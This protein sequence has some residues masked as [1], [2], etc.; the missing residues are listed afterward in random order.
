[1]NGVR[2]YTKEYAKTH[3]TQNNGIFVSG[4]DNNSVTE[5]YGELKNILELRYPSQNL[6][7]LFDCY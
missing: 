4:D 6:V 1:V 5:Y 3:T 2:Y 7:Y